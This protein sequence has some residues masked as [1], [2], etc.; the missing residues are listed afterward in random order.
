MVHD[1]EHP[2]I[3]PMKTLGL[4]IKSTGS[5]TEIRRPAP[6]HGQHSKEVLEFLDYN[7]NEIQQF[8]D[9]KTVVNSHN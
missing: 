6:W 2:R 1:I 3:G 5:L 4:P 9:S 7:S 8:F